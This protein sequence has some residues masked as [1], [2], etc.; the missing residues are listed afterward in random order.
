MSVYL[1]GEDNISISNAAARSIF[2]FKHPR[3]VR[4]CRPPRIYPRLSSTAC[5]QLARP[6][7]D[8]SGGGKGVEEGL[9]PQSGHD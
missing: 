9:G 4:V 7:S 8:I 6:R 5:S 3:R 2:D 1:F